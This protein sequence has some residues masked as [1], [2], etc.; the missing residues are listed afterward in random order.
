MLEQ[1]TEKQFMSLVDTWSMET[2]V[3]STLIM[4]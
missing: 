4:S 2:L 3:D 1:V